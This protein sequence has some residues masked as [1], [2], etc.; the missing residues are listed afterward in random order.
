[1]YDYFFYGA[2][3]FPSNGNHFVKAAKKG[4]MPAVEAVEQLV[5][6]DHVKALG[7]L[8][9]ES[10]VFNAET[11]KAAYDVVIAA[12]KFDCFMAMYDSDDMSRKLNNARL[13]LLVQLD[14]AGWQDAFAE[15]SARHEYVH[16]STLFDFIKMDMP[17]HIRSAMLTSHTSVSADNLLDYAASHAPEWLTY[18]L[19]RMP[20][21]P[22]P[23][24]M[25][26]LAVYALGNSGDAGHIK[27]AVELLLSRGMNVNYDNGAVMSAVLSK[28]YIELAQKLVDAGFEA[29]LCRT[30]VYERL[31]AIGAPRAGIDF[32]K[33]FMGPAVTDGG[34]GHDGFT[35]S[36]DYSVSCVQPLPNG[37]QLTMV[38]NFATSQQ[39]VIAQMGEQLAAPTVVPFSRIESRYLLEKA[40]DAFVAAGG[41]ADLASACTTVQRKSPVAKAAPAA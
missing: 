4:S 15:V 41:D 20:H 9:A 18:C 40:A 34:K 31:C 35:R 29:A 37:G 13:R 12:R 30:T 3:M 17:E 33:Q 32:I 36:D 38:F 10:S 22:N 5:A 21:A 39:I 24:K 26:Q 23:N 2:S 8:M 14:T 7:K 16:T 19:D 28:G 25:A 1:M 27:A 11:R 6:G